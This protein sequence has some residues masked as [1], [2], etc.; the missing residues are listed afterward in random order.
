[1]RAVAD[2]NVVLSGLLWQGYPRQILRAAHLGQLD[3]F[4]S[5]PLLAELEDVLSRPA[6][7]GRLLKAKVTARQLLLGYAALAHL[8]QPAKIRPVV[9]DDPADDAVLA[10]AIGARAEIIITGDHHLRDLQHYRRIPILSPVAA[11]V[12]IS[13]PE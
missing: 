13:R 2:T 11:L 12:R 8:V 1:M 10:C 4:T 3:L 7:G 9:R 5:A 6:F